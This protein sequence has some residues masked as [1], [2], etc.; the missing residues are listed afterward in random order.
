MIFDR[1]PSQCHTVARHVLFVNWILRST[2][3]VNALDHAP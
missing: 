1:G 3:F 2:G